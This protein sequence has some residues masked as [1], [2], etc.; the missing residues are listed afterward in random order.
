MSKRSFGKNICCV[1]DHFHSLYVADWA[2][3]RIWLPKNFPSPVR[4]ILPCRSRPRKWS[5][6]T[7]SA[8]PVSRRSARSP[9]PDQSSCLLAGSSPC[10]RFPRLRRSKSIRRQG[11]NLYLS[12][13]SFS[14]NRTMAY[15]WRSSPRVRRHRARNNQKVAQ[16]V[17]MR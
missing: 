12:V 8:V 16:N 14:G 1:G 9:H 15:R 13:T 4:A 6:K 7:S 10:S 3:T 2:S 11:V 5:R 17:R